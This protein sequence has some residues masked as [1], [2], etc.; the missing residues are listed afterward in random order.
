MNSAGLKFLVFIL[1]GVLSL[2]LGYKLRN[3]KAAASGLSRNIHLHTVL[4]SWSPFF[5]IGFWQ[6][7]LSPTLAYIMLFQPVMMGLIWLLVLG[8]LRYT[9]YTRETKGV[10]LLNSLLSNQG[11]TLGGLPLFCFTEARGAGA[12]LRSCLYYLSTDLRNPSIIS[13]GFLL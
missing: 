3:S 10:V 6:F 7:K 8:V 11:F 1:F 4:W 13:S 2:A 9:N 12:L 5:M